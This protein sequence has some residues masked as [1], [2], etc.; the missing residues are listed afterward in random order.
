VTPHGILLIDSYAG[1]AE[2][3]VW[4]VGETLKRYRVMPRFKGFKLRSRWVMCGDVVLVPK[5]AVRLDSVS[6]G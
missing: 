3:K 6:N 1:R 4:I 2:H 5:T